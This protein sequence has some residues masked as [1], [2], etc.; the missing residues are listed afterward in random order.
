MCKSLGANFDYFSQD[1]KPW[2]HNPAYT[3]KENERLYMFWDACHMI[4]IIRNTLGGKNVLINDE[5]NTI[6]WDYI[7]ELQN[8][9]ESKGLHA[10]NKLKKT[11][12]NYYENKMNVRLAVKTLSA[13]V[14]SGL[15]FCKELKLLSSS[16]PTSEFCKMF[17]DAFNIL[18]CRNRLGK[19]DYDFS[20]DEKT[21]F[22]IKTFTEKF[23]LYVK[24]LKFEPSNSYSGGQK[25]L[26]CQ[27]KTGFLGLIICLN[28]LIHLYEVIKENWNEL[29][30]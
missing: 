30:I 2:F 22:K 11:N 9:Q 3:E 1:F 8:I 16:K 12:I 14:S 21:I 19:G 5:G 26:I 25:I 13:S 15:L 4:K 17:N 23:I 18:N 29:L 27:R 7:K 10:E 6:K 20:T 24:G 28:N